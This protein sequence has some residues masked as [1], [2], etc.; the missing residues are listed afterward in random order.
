M[1]NFLPLT[2]TQPLQELLGLL[3]NPLEPQM[4]ELSKIFNRC[5][6]CV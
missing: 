6:E 1:A 4:E 3:V 2:N 5:N